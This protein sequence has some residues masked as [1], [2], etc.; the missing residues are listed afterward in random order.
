MSE[1]C[2]HAHLLLW[3]C[4]IGM[5]N[6]RNTFFSVITTHSYIRCVVILKF[7]K[8]LEQ[9]QQKIGIFI[10]VRSLSSRSFSFMGMFDWNEDLIPLIQSPG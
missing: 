4:L 5:N 1:A 6:C 10:N 9:K 8:P 2:L 7:C 3:P